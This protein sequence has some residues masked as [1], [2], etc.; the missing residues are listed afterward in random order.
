MSNTSLYQQIMGADYATLAAPLQRFHQL[1]GHHVLHGWVDIAPPASWLTKLLALG[2]PTQ[3]ASGPLRFDLQTQ[4]DTQIWTRHFPG[5]T[6][7]SRL[8][9]QGPHLQEHLGIARLA[10]GLRA[11]NGSLNMELKSL[12]V[13]GLACPAWLR[14]KIIALESGEGNDQVRFQVSA[15][16]PLIGLVASYSGHLVVPEPQKSTSESGYAASCQ[17]LAKHHNI[18]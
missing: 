18:R 3:G 17:Y 15:T 13:M 10:F 11:S 12:R 4:A 2:T 6:M 7:S 5:K 8:S 14:P 9:L 1:S 16:L